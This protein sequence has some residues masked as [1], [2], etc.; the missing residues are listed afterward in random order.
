MNNMK[1]LIV[2]MLV[3]VMMVTVIPGDNLKIAKAADYTSA[4]DMAFTGTWSE[5]R[6]I[7]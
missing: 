4:S 7:T 1:R 6:W 3:M 2:M 5:D